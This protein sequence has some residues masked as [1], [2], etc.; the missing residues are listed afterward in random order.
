M[1][2]SHTAS[3]GLC[4]T[5]GGITGA[6]Y[7]VGA[8]A[9]IER[10]V[11]GFSASELDVIVGAGAGAVVAAALAGGLTATR[12]YRA[13]LDPADDLFP[14]ERHHLIRVSVIEAR[15]MLRATIGALRRFL[16]SATTRPLDAEPWQALDR[17][18]DSLPAGVLTLRAFEAF[19]EDVFK[20][21]GVPQRFAQMPRA[22]FIVA[23]DLDLGE[24]VVF[25][26]GRVED[27]TVLHAAIA[28]CATP[29][30]YAPV[31]VGRR[32]CIAGEVGEL[33]HADV[34]VAAGAG[35]I[36][37]VNPVVPI[38]T[39]VRPGGARGVPGG[40][41]A[42]RVRDKGL[43]WVHSQAWRAHVGRLGPRL[44]AYEATL[45]D[46]AIACVEPEPGDATMFM[47]SPMSYAARRR[48][49]EHAYTTTTRLLR[50]P[51]S[52]LAAA[53]RGAGLTPSDREG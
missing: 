29:V 1:P 35:T 13:L 32:D 45:D 42:R 39:D 44:K 53:L 30:L 47:H 10:A 7:E 50:E 40:R 19:L 21:R 52:S 38:R 46:V 14:L 8:L 34:A 11:D 25:G 20:R 28:S 18:Y 15:R 37:V 2:E 23:T 33:G 6:M 48:I 51:A 31:R 49:L 3:L 36:L 27:A 4:L 5:G 12:M 16:G 22:L 24:R 9:A 17:L 26:P 41:S 43:L